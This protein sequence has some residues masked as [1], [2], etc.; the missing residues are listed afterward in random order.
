MDKCSS[1]QQFHKSNAITII[2]G[3][4]WSPSHRELGLMGG[5]EAVRQTKLL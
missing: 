3:K 1:E 2:V 5:R 4:N